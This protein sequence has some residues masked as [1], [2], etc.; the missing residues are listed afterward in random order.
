MKLRVLM[1]I[2]LLLPA[3]AMAETKI[4]TNGIA[5]GAITTPKLGPDS[6]TA[7]KIVDGAVGA[8]EIGAEAVGTSEVADG[9]L[10]AADLAP[11]LDLSGKTLTMPAGALLQVATTQAGAVATGTTVLP[12]DDTIPQIT[13]GDQYLT[14]AITP[15]SAASKLRVD[16][17]FVGTISI[18]GTLTVALFQDATANALAATAVTQG[19]AGE[20][21]TVTL[22]HYM[23]AGTTSSTTFRIRAGPSGAGTTTFNGTAAARRYGGV[24]ASSITV[25]EIAQ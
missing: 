4:Q 17:V 15:R 22:T 16:V 13:E 6:V 11:A 10:V 20:M 8:A 18:A 25:A 24:M 14:V 2:A 19:A 21:Q 1:L 3:I 7:G 12:S 5:D 9:S 23:T